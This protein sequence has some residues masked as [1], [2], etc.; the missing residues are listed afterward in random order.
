MMKRLFAILLLLALLSACTAQPRLE[1]TGA[2]YY[3]FRDSTD[4]QVVLEKKPENVAVLFSSYAQIWTCA[5][6]QVGVTVGESIERGFVSA[7][8]VL[9]DG[10]AGKSIDMELLLSAQPDFVIGSADIPAQVEACKNA[11]LAGIP[12]ALFQV[13]TVADYLT[14]L[15]IC[16]DITENT[17]AYTTYGIQVQQQVNQILS[18]VK[19]ANT[20]GKK[21]LFIRA[22]SQYSATKAKRAPENFVCTMLQQLGAYN[23]ADDADILLDGLSLEAVMLQDPEHIFLTTMGAE[24]A[25]KS[26]IEDLFSQDGW[27][28]LQAVKT[29][30]YTFLDKELFHFK[31]NARW[32]EAYEILAELLYP[33][34][35]MK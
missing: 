2:P 17:E 21:I 25:A 4:A 18:A 20:A 16:T 19:D 27:K 22:G 9:V 26:Y 34:L 3:V 6:G 35:D 28:D 8:A 5:G 31:P 7:D 12:A 29:G 32:A 15:K 14:M 10:G 23:I 11:A 1:T 33:E 30:N 24:V 13:D